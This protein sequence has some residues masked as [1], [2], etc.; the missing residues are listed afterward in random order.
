MGVKHIP[1]RRH[2]PELL[3]EGRLI[4]RCGRIVSYARCI[5]SG[6]AKQFR[7]GVEEDCIEDAT[8]KAC[9]L[10]DLRQQRRD[11]PVGS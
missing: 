2:T 5:N 8:C 3:A 7:P 9:E 6:L 11:N 1:S 10:S 4:T